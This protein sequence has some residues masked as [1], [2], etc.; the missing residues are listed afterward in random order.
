M[1][2]LTIITELLLWSCQTLTLLGPIH[3]EILFHGVP[4]TIFS[5]LGPRGQIW[6]TYITCII[7]Y[8]N[9]S[10]GLLKQAHT[11]DFGWGVLY[12]EVDFSGPSTNLYTLTNGRIQDLN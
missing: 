5:P 8:T 2:D 12:Q 7:A 6:N 3:F 4:S 9:S 11:Q 10:L 1:P